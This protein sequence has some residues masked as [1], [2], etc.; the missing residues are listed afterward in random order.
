MPPYQNSINGK[1]TGIVSSKITWDAKNKKAID[2][3]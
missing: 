3:A 1:V 2:K